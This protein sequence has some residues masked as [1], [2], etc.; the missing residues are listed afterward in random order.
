MKTNKK[1]VDFSKKKVLGIL[2][3]ASPPPPPFYFAEIYRVSVTKKPYQSTAFLTTA[4]GFI[5]NCCTQNKAISKQGHRREDEKN[6][7]AA[8]SKL[9]KM[10]PYLFFCSCFVLL[11]VLLW[12]RYG[13]KANTWS[14]KN[15]HEEQMIF[16]SLITLY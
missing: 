16:P 14:L 10:F 5:E 7:A 1:T 8:F 4:V 9:D 15:L 6:R 2:K 3:I 12:Y 13:P 11:C